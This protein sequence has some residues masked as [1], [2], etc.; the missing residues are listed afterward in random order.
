MVKVQLKL[1]IWS[2]GERYCLQKTVEL[3]RHPCVGESLSVCITLDGTTADRKSKELVYVK[4]PITMVEGNET[5]AYL[6]K[7]G[8]ISRK[9]FRLACIVGCDWT[10]Y[11]L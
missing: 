1:H 9:K 8:R 4:K 7:P 2:L 3:S 5:S 6:V 10:R 11:S